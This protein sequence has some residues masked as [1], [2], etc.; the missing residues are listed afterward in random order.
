MRESDIMKKTALLFNLIQ[1][2]KIEKKEYL[3]L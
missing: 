2:E 1:K 3:L